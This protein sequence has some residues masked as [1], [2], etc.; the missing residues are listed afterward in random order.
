MDLN[1]RLLG[2]TTEI[3]THVAY[4]RLSGEAVPF[5]LDVR[6]PHEYVAG[7]IQAA[8]LIPLGQLAGRLAELPRDRE[9]LCI[10]RSGA[11]SL[12]ATRQLQAAGYRAV[13]LGGGMLA[14]SD[15]GLPVARGQG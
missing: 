15:A 9:I 8:V 2:L 14:W 11:R 13:N 12:S 3:G 4:E 1:S 7:H 5:L 6:E 10:C